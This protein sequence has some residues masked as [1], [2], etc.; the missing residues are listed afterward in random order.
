MKDKIMS[1]IIRNTPATTE[2][3]SRRSGLEMHALGMSLTRRK[4]IAAGAAALA[5]A[6]CAKARG[7]GPI[8][9]CWGDSLTEGWGAPRGLDYPSVLRGLFSGERVVSNHGRSGETSV[10]IVSRFNAAEVLG[11]DTSVFWMGHNNLGQPD[12]ILDDIE[13]CFNRLLPTS[14]GERRALILTLLNGNFEDHREGAPVHRQI[15]TLNEQIMTRWPANS[16][17]IRTLMVRASSGVN[18]VVSADWRSDDIHLNEHGSTFV[19]AQVK[20][21]LVGKG[22]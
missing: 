9:S 19:A 6:G 2:S 5:L 10:Q 4:F 17:D 7:P 12:Q 21:Y 11:G 16:F 18:D 13:S 3:L 15:L 20:A 22:W 1:T 14:S 8:I